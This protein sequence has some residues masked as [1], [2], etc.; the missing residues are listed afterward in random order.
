LTF[1]DLEI[2]TTY[3][4]GV[5]GNDVVRAFY[6]PVLEKTIKYDRVAG[7]FSSKVF[8]SVARGI[9]GIVRNNG[10]IR[11]VTSHVLTKTDTTTLQSYYDSEDFAENLIKEFTDSFKELDDLSS[12]ISKLHVQALCWLLKEGYLE[13]RIVVPN[14][15]DLINLNPA[16]IEKFHPKFGIMY[17]NENRV[18]AFSGSINET[19]GAWKR[20]IE[21]FD[22]YASWLP[23]RMDYI[24]PKIQQ[25]E[26]YWNSDID[27]NWKTIP[28]PEAVK[29]KI[30]NDFAPNDF[31]S[32]ISNE[33]LEVRDRPL[34]DYQKE[35]L[36]AWLDSNRVGILEMATGTGKTRTARACFESTLEI[37]SLLT[38]VIVP[39]QH[40]GT[41]WQNEFRNYNPILVSGDWRKKLALIQK[42]ITLGRIQNLLLI[43]V[44]NTAANPEFI[45]Y[46]NKL[47][48]LFENTLVIADEVHWLGANAY[49]SALVEC[50]N[51]RLG[52]SAT[53]N[54]YFDDEG[55]KIIFDYFL[56]SVFEL[57]ISQALKLKDENGNPILCPYVYRPI[58]VELNQEEIDLYR[59][60]SQKIAV[61]RNLENSSDFEAQI[62]N[63]Y[64]KRSLIV[65]NAISKFS[66]LEVLLEKLKESLTHTLIYCSD[67]NQL[68]G[69]A[70]ILNRM[71]ID[72]Q[73][74]TGQESTRI[75]E[76]Y[77]FLSERDHILKNFAEGNLEVLLAIDCLDEGVDIPAAFRGILMAS[78]GNPKEFIQRR[79]RLMRPFPGKKLAE[80]YDFCVLPSDPLDPVGSLA[81]VEVELKRIKE[82]G[83][84]AVNS[85][86]IDAMVSDRLQRLGR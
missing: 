69:S 57:S 50:A 68:G 25:F 26:K 1:L 61:L 28:L 76:D 67:F 4:S 74:I 22:A 40:I 12:T 9:A 62:Q 7:Y 53:P 77:N 85:D 49:R 41:Q 46:V 78:S 32:E 27:S 2:G 75:T 30:I 13:I 19:E 23:G 72:I 80:I 29:S 31:P 48:K 35:A 45:E 66:N 15:A 11:L 34:R 36:V 33:S 10:R 37:G 65:K 16:E 83:S 86:E 44:K 51:F 71:N 18:V 59:E 63:L 58:F 56:R 84:D 5:G 54:R 39:Y 20:N 47:S 64:I 21:N 60:I 70:A 42:D 81:L 17:D 43:A 38:V 73:Q 52:L 24:E 79:G 8:A 3:D 14:S 6:I 82:F 55:T